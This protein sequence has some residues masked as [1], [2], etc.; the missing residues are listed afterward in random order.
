MDKA[1]RS[2]QAE[3]RAAP[4][5]GTKA[6][7]D[8]MWLVESAAMNGCVVVNS[9]YQKCVFPTRLSGNKRNRMRTIPCNNHHETE[10]SFH[11]IL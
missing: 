3:T 10:A 1:M 4:S 5:P 7:N 2:D 6:E 11:H 8:K 9:K